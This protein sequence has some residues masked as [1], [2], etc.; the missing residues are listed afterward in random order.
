[1]AIRAIS[2]PPSGNIISISYDDESLSL[3]VEFKRGKVY[4]YFPVDEST[5]N[6]F[7]QALNANGYFQS[8]IKD[9][10]EYERLS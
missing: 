2:A 10:F 4:R 6:G 5:A 3:F 7:S 1:M 9:V 8:F